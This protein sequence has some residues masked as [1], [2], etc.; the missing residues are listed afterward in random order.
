[1]MHGTH[2]QQ[3]KPMLTGYPCL[4]CRFVTPLLPGEKVAEND[5]DRMCVECQQRSTERIG[6]DFDARELGG[7]S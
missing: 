2:E 7:E 4:C 3:R 1:M 5:E 6:L